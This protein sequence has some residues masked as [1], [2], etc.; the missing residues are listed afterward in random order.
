MIL[1]TSIKCRDRPS[2]G[3]HES[4]F[5]AVSCLPS[6]PCTLYLPRPPVRS[7]SWM[8]V[9][10]HSQ[11]APAQGS[12][13]SVRVILA[14]PPP[15]QT[16]RPAA[17]TPWS[18]SPAARPGPPTRK[19][20]TLLISPSDT[21]CLSQTS[22]K[23][24]NLRPA[25]ATQ[26]QEESIRPRWAT[27]SSLRLQGWA[28]L[29]LRN[30]MGCSSSNTS[31]TTTTSTLTTFPTIHLSTISM[32]PLLPCRLNHTS[33]RAASLRRTPWSPSPDRHA[34]LYLGQCRARSPSP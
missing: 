30:Q 6:L 4:F 28:A 9:T 16:P 21:A 31:F 7:P 17:Q 23:E 26:P 2:H 22:W 32:S 25:A 1:I 14:A 15:P 20:W 27:R 3:D 19:T 34:R 5:I 33:E 24:L 11:A 13:P 29:E 18:L 12:P 10:P 8:A